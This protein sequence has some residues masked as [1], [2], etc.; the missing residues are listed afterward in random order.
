MLVPHDNRGCPVNDS[1]SDKALEL[2]SSHDMPDIPEDAEHSS[3]VI[4]V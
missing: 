4:T 2:T 1:I 3:E